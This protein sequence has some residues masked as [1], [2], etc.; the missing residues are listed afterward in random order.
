MSEANEN[1]NTPE[2]LAHTNGQTEFLCFDLGSGNHPSI[3]YEPVIASD[4]D[5]RINRAFDLLFQEVMTVRKI[6]HPHEISRHIRQGFNR[7][8]GR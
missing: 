6:N 5:D 2:N 1:S 3:A 8:A 7:P 4:G